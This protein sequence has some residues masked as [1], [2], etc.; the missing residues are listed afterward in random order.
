MGNRQLKLG[1]GVSHVQV[2]SLRRLPSKPIT[3]L[4][5]V[6]GNHSLLRLGGGP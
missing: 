3:G 4:A 6:P 2:I 1:M 5:L